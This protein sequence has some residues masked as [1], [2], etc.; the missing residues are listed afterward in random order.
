MDI[1]NG[2]N[3]ILPLIQKRIGTISLS[4]IYHGQDRTASFTLMHPEGGLL[5]IHVS[6]PG[7]LALNGPDKPAR[8]FWIR[9]DTRVGR[10]RLIQHGRGPAR[11]LPHRSTS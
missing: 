6:R 2:L 8:F 5:T 9:S 7:I 11:P 10:D 1:E 4:F 3:G